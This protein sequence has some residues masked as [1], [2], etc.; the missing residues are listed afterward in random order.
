MVSFELFGWGCGSLVFV[1]LL[2]I[3]RRARA[4]LLMWGMVCVAW[5]GMSTYWFSGG[6]DLGARYWYQMVVPLTVLTVFGV[7]EFAARLHIQG[8]R[9]EPNGL[10]GQTAWAVVALA[11]LLGLVNLVPWRGVDKYMNY[12][13][14]GGHVGRLAREHQFGRSLVFVRGEGPLAPWSSSAF[15]S[16]FALN[17]LTFDPDAPGPIYVRDLGVESRE[18]LRRYYPDRPAWILGTPKHTSGEFQLLEGPI[19]PPG[20]PKE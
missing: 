19:P 5:L 14:V 6:P 7:Q 2:V 11:S 1:F 15:A 10:C 12:R 18:R 13:Y 9:P 16:A 4:D 8:A 3:W 20:K 17:P